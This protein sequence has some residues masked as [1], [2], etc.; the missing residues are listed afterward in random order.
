[1]PLFLYY[2]AHLKTI[3]GTLNKM[4]I[5]KSIWGFSRFHL[6]NHKH[7][8]HFQSVFLNY[9]PAMVLQFNLKD[10]QAL[11]EA[12][13]AYFSENNYDPLFVSRLVGQ[14]KRLLECGQEHHV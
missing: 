8:D 1:M 6:G 10:I 3:L 7:M 13:S 12:M 14:M 11:L 9:V 5:V 2:Q 4:W